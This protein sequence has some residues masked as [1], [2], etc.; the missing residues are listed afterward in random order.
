MKNQIQM[1]LLPA[2]IA[3][4]L[5]CPPARAAVDLSRVPQNLQVPV[6]AADAQHALLVWNK[7][8]NYQD[9]RDYKVFMDGKLLGS[10]LENLRKHSPAQPYVDRFY[11]SDT[12]GE[13]ARVSPHHFTVTGLKPGSE[14][15]FSV[16]A[17]LPGGKLS[18]PSEVFELVTPQPSVICDIAA[19]G[20]VGD[21]VS[22]NTGVIQTTIDHCPAG[23]TVRVPRGVFKTGA[24]FLKSDMTLELVEGAT[25]LGS[26]RAEDY[27]LERGYTLY[28][29]STT[30]RPPSLLNALDPKGKHAGTFSNIRIVGAGILDGGGWKRTAAAS[31]KDETGREL[32]QYIFGTNRSVHNDGLLAAAQV[33]Q[34][35]KEGMPLGVAYSQRRSSLVTLRGVQNV[36]IDGVTLRNPAFHGVMVLESEDVTVNAVRLETFDT[37]NGDGLEFGNSRNI[38]VVGSFFDTG[39]DC[40]NFAAG[41]GADAAKQPPMKGAW[42]FNNYMRKGHGAVV[43]G[44]H[45][46]AWIEDILA[47]DNVVN[48]TWTGLRAKTNNINGGGG[49]NIIYRDNAHRDLQREG[50]VLTTEYSDVNAFIDYKPAAETGR[51]VNV[52][53]QNNS[54]EY[55]ADWKPTPVSQGTNGVP[56]IYDF[57]PVL[58]LGDSKRQA[59]HENVVFDGLKLINTFPV[60]IDGLKNGAIQNVL[61]RRS[62]AEGMP[63]KVDNA[64][65]FKMKDV[66]IDKGD[67][68]KP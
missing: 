13:H 17:V 33:A 45:T 18:A 42:I 14:H 19:H 16:R 47:E 57:P 9:V 66:Q 44:S 50:F 38:M 54:L 59:F 34:A 2:M 26:E 37:N 25:L 61:F 32:P 49:R 1:V 55:T 58:V 35:V 11:D 10:A 23:G 62:K 27:P 22:L 52:L 24:L 20:A 56:G 60:K 68:Q 29:Y 39:D 31:I 48:L 28:E 36:F 12:K 67:G 40:V 63:W 6:L 21:G 4:G 41:T 7:P 3:L 46:G 51:F 43:L 53:V 15:R 30:Q 65:G 8:A 64:P 5:S